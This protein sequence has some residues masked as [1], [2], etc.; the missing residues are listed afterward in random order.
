MESVEVLVRILEPSIE[1]V[2]TTDNDFSWTSWENT[3]EAVKEI[4]QLMRMVKSG[5]LPSRKKVGILFAPT[6]PLQELSI[7]SSWGD[8]FLTMAEKYDQVAPLVWKK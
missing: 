5:R 6:G 1:L 8:L 3:K 4:N 7:S 2:E